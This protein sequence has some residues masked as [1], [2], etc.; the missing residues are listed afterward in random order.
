MTSSSKPSASETSKKIKH[1]LKELP[2]ERADAARLDELRKVFAKLVASG[3]IK[4]GKSAENSIAAKWQ[5][6]LAKHHKQMVSQL[7]E[8]IEAGKRS[9]IR[10][11]WGVIAASP[12]TSVN[13]LYTYVNPALMQKWIRSMSRLEIEDMDKAMRHMVESEFL[14]PYRDVQFYALSSLTLVAAEQYEKQ[15]KGATSSHIGETLL[16][17]LMMIP[18]PESHDDLETGKFLFTPPK[19][20]VPDQAANK[21]DD[22]DEDGDDSSSEEEDE[23]S[24]ESDDDD[25]D[26]DEEETEKQNHRHLRPKK[27]QKTGNEKKFSF[28]QLR[29]FRREY[30]KA[31]LAI[32]KLSLPIQSLKRALQ[33]LPSQVLPSVSHPL[34]FSDFFIQAY[35]DHGSGALG[36]LALDGLFLLITEYGLE[37]PEFYKQLY[38]LVSSRVL[39]AKYRAKFFSLLTKCLARNEMLPAH[40]V[41]AF[42]K[43]LCRSALSAP[44]PGILFVLAL[45]SNLL[46]K[47]PECSCLIQRKDGTEMDDEFDASEDDPVQ[48]KALQSSLWELAVLERHYH[49]AIGTLAKSIGSDAESKGPLHDM[50]EFSSHTYK[51]LFD[52][53]RKKK[54]KTALTFTEPTS[55]FTNDDI[56]SGSLSFQ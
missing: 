9:A 38:R 43:R 10:C 40:L 54:T 13:G 49:P 7:C 29:A 42:V 8:R 41:A 45:T 48:T 17:L 53:D 15:Q 31:W 34:R 46:R 25:E 24:K 2:E 36:V 22:G 4:F 21:E 6:F 11:M 28:Q 35:T 14:H 51:S 19:D 1:L 3:D 18:I 44:P 23:E 37:Y 52:Q 50:T 32:L 16:E 12:Q 27:R 20:A 26:S 33:F 56:F 47:H 30:E 55:L 5:A 39:Y